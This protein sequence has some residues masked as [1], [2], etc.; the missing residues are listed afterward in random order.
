MFGDLGKTLAFA[1]AGD[2]LVS[3]RGDFETRRRGERRGNVRTTTLRPQRL[4][5]SNFVGEE[6]S[7]HHLAQ[8]A[9]VDEQNFA[10]PVAEDRGSSD[11]LLFVFVRNKMSQVL[12]RGDAE[13]AEEVCRQ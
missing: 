12:K 1:E 11:S 8:L 6:D 9:G 13:S 3:I 2:V 7:V 5:V 10:R 4:C